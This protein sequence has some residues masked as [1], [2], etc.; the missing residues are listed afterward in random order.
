MKSS[1][2]L[3][4]LL[5]IFLGKLNYSQDTKMLDAHYP[6]KYKWS[7]TEAERE[8]KNCLFWN[9]IKKGDI[10]A[11]IGAY[12]GH[13][14]LS[15]SLF[16]EGLT[17]YLQEPQADRL[18][19]NGFYEMYNHFTKE[20][21]KP[22]TNQ[23]N[24]IIGDNYH[25]NLPDNTFDKV[26]MNSVFEYIS[27]YDL[28]L[29]DLKTKLKKN[30]KVY[31][32]TDNPFKAEYF[33]KIFET[34]GYTCEKHATKGG[35]LQMV[36]NTTEKSN[37]SVNDI[38]DAVIQKDYDK[39]KAYL[40]NGVSVNST[41]GI[42]NLLQIA[43]SI[44]NN[45]KILQ[46]LIDK[47][48]KLNTDN[49]FVFTPLGKLAASGE[50]E[51]VKLLLDNGAKPTDEVLRMSVWFGHN[52]NVVKSLIEKGAKID[53]TNE[54]LLFAAKGCDLK[55]ITYLLNQ[56]DS[57]I[58]FKKDK[59]GQSFIHWSA[60]GYNK[61]VVKYLLDEKKFIINEKDNEEMTVLMHAVYGGSIDI[62]KYLIEEKQMNINEKNKQ[63]FSALHYALDPEI[64]KYLIS[65]GAL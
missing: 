33:I 50:Y 43:G 29:K 10:I 58:V 54:V 26:F 28:Y 39:T 52:V 11:D 8:L 48:A 15:L 60:K 47:G 36:F 34:Y 23:F 1:T 18:N 53:G 2:F 5:F 59:N 24:F 56:V 38:F 45:Q 21:G 27:R 3:I 63:G 42:A 57:N 41:L 51:A 17:F 31:V 12:S 14:D 16:Y 65:K 55:I 22:I 62:L 6:K 64:S 61:D 9:D 49:F 7:K 30:G 13:I 32:K 25:T 40:D 46:L 37:I 35:W 4:I 19:K 20:N 44:S